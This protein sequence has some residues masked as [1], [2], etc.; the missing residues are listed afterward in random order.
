MINERK[1]PILADVIPSLRAVKKAEPKILKP[2]IKNE[3]VQIS[4]AIIV[5]S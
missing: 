4:S 3:M 2:N 5:T 1:K